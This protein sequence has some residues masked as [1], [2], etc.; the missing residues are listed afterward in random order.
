MTFGISH[1]VHVLYVCFSCYYHET[2][3][4]YLGRGRRPDPTVTLLGRLAWCRALSRHAYI[5]PALHG[6]TRQ[7]SCASYWSARYC[8]RRF[9]GTDN[10]RSAAIYHLNA[11]KNYRLYNESGV[12]YRVWPSSLC[13]EQNK[14]SSQP[15]PSFMQAEHF[16]YHESLVYSIVTEPWTTICHFQDS[17]WNTNTAPN[18]YL[19]SALFIVSYHQ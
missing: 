10:L 17:K 8:I 9:E 14:T 1:S 18:Q 3:C 16:D 13:L 4:I 6:V 12:G 2:K 15:Q 7:W 19:P 5:S 11:L